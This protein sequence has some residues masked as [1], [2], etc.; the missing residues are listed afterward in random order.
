MLDNKELVNFIT[1]VSSS[2]CKSSNYD[3]IDVD[4]VCSNQV[5]GWSGEGVELDGDSSNETTVTCVSSHLTS[6]AVL[7]SLQDSDLVRDNL[8]YLFH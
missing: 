3:P 4:D 6:F 7:V 5:G 8:I 2:T 1:T